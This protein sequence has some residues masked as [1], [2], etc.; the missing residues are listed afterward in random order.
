MDA[1]EP[2]PPD[3]EAIAAE[4]VDSAIKIHRQLGPG[5][6]ESV[7]ERC[8]AHELTLRGFLVERQ[9]PVPIVYEGLFL[10]V[11]YRLD[12][13]VNKSVVVECKAVKDLHPIDHQQILTHIRL[14]GLRLGF[15]INFNVMRLID[16][17]HRKI[18]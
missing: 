5:L 10:D 6:L 13:L 9:V 8:L 7:Y 18:N 14:A 11:G 1:F 16:G 12:L 15:L 17:L 4:I 3:L 2:L